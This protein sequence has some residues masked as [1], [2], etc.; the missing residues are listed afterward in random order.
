MRPAEFANGVVPVAVEDA[1]VERLRTS[2]RQRSVLC[3][4]SYATLD[5]GEF[6]RIVVNEFPEQET[7]QP[8][9]GTG[10]A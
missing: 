1:V 10:L 3:D 6:S 2:N 7:P 4:V 9:R 5:C 8:Q